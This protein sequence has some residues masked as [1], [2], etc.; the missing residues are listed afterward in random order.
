[1]DQL[2]SEKIWNEY[3]V[4]VFSPLFIHHYISLYI[5]SDYELGIENG[6]ERAK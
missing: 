5:D 4:W 3:R 6:K 1:M 2:I